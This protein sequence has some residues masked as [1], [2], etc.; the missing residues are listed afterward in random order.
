MPD[1]N[2]PCIV[3]MDLD[4]F[5]VSVS[6]LLHPELNHK[7]VIVGGGER[8]VVAACSYEARRFGVHS[9]MPVKLARRLC[10][11]AIVIRGDYDAYSRYSDVVNEIISE[12]VP[13]YE[14]S[15]IDEFYID[16]TGMDRFFGSYKYATGLRQRIIRETGLPISFGM[17]SGKTVS[18]V[19]TGEAKPNNQLRVDFGEEKNF[20][21]PLSVRKIPMVGEKTYTLLRSMGVEKV[22]TI[23]E[24]PVELMQKVLGENG[25]TLWK[26]ANGIDF[27][28]VEPYHEQ[29]S[30][31]TEETFEQDTID[32]QRLHH[33]L[34]AMT[35]KLCF[36]LRSE[37]K[38]TSCVCVKLRYSNFDTHT[39]QCRIPY[40]N[41]DH[42]ILKHVKELFNKLYNRRLLVRLIGI[43]FSH[44]V[45][46]GHQINLFEDSGK[47]ISLYQA[48]DKMRLRFGEDKIHRAAALHFSL[49]GFNPFNGN[50]LSPAKD[51]RQT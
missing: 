3:H 24:M 5:F 4:C 25:V 50:S 49:R 9:A 48:M 45:G 11:E 27:S 1:H 36:R 23:Q 44:L 7:P 13:L 40:T 37:R 46:G 34:I 15:S 21:A 31:S 51:I 30:I 32:V 39:M 38:V 42:L 8:G 33:L 35:E 29:K 43:R 22:K 16:L 20:L 19:A 26:K 47:M 14:R 12:S 41:C 2:R 28:P 17:S 10:P 6:R 18:K